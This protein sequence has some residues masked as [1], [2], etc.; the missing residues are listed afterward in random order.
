MTMR[1]P[2]HAP[3]QPGRWLYENRLERVPP[4]IGRLKQLQ[5]LWLDRNVLVELTPAIAG[6]DKLQVPPRD[7]VCASACGCK[8]WR[9][10]LHSHL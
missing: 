5:R 9:A 4:E 1:P 2:M 7:A 10:K 8:S 3:I 6:C